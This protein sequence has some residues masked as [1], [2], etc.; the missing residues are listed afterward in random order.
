MGGSAG[1]PPGDGG[2]GVGGAGGLTTTGGGGDA[3]INQVLCNGEM[4][5][6]GAVCCVDSAT[7]AW[8]G[9]AAAGSCAINEIGVA[10]DGPEDCPDAEVCCGN[11]TDHYL[12]VECAAATD[13]L[14]FEPFIVMCGGATGPDVQLCV[15]GGICNVSSDLP[16]YYYCK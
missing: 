5:E 8:V 3:P 16:G 4:C 11:H 6:V 14:G 2:A 9:C 1:G 13:C 10:C 12:A 7:N 15:N